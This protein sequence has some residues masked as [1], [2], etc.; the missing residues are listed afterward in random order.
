MIR[1]VKSEAWYSCDGHRAGTLRIW[2]TPTDTHRHT[3]THTH[4]HAHMLVWVMGAKCGGLEVAV[5]G[6]IISNKAGVVVT[7]H[8]GH[9]GPLR[10]R[11]T[12]VAQMGSAQTGSLT[13]PYLSL[14][15]PHVYGLC[16]PI[17]MIWSLHFAQIPIF[18]GGLHVLFV[19][20]GLQ[21]GILQLNTRTPTHTHTQVGICNFS[22]VIC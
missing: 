11:Q 17:C 16:V 8:A 3:H 6:G 10:R 14:W 1:D 7:W 22:M 20:K 21:R 9:K 15:P 12:G 13:E 5:Q 18:R 19:K 4:T 2:L